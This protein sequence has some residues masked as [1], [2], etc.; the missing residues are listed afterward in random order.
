MSKR[1]IARLSNR[2]Q[3]GRVLGDFIG[4]IFDVGRFVVMR[5]TSLTVGRRAKMDH[6]LAGSGD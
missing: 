3:F 6:H 1:S 4:E 5:L 2:K